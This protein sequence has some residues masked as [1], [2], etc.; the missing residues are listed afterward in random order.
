L[1]AWLNMEYI[2]LKK[3]DMKAKEM[4]TEVRNMG[5][6]PEI[7]SNPQTKH[8]YFLAMIFTLYSIKSEVYMPYLLDGTGSKFQ[9]EN[10]RNKHENLEGEQLEQILNNLNC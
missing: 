7:H 4:Y 5:V 10:F 1:L 6:H 8:I 3:L 2:D 9:W